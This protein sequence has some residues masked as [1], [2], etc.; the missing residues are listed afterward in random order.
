[1]SSYKGCA[2]IFHCPQRVP[3][4]MG[5]LFTVYIEHCICV[6]EVHTSLQVGSVLIV[7]ILSNLQYDPSLYPLPIHGI[8][9]SCIFGENCRMPQRSWDRCW[10]RPLHLLPLQRHSVL[11][12]PITAFPQ[13]ESVYYL[14]IMVAVSTRLIC[15]S[16]K[17]G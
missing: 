12:L 7:P 14:C 8:M 5:V 17:S 15:K 3:T 13:A 9:Q 1:M 6:A 16:L 10:G 2:L 11:L 4:T